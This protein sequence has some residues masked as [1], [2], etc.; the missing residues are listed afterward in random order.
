MPYEHLIFDAFIYFF[1]FAIGLGIL[2]LSGRVSRSKRFL[3]VPLVFILS[4][5]WLA[6]F[7]GSFIEPKMIR[8]SF[9]NVDLNRSSSA[10]KIEKIK[11]VVLSDLHLGPYNGQDLVKK[12][13]KRV[14]AL[15]PDLVILAGD[16]I[17]YKNKSLDQ[18][19]PLADLVAPM[20]IL[21]VTGNHD[22]QENVEEVIDALSKYHVNFLR[23]R[24]VTIEVD[25]HELFIAGVNDYW[26]DAMDLSKA[27]ASATPDQ[28]VLLVAHN[29]DVVRYL[30][31]GAKVDLMISGHTH[32]GQIRLPWLGP[33]VEP[34]TDLPREYAH[35]LKIYDNVKMLISAGLGEVGPRARLF[36]PPEVV[37][38]E[39]IF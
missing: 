14:N 20:G 10:E 31:Q 1:L 27:L 16:Y 33:L 30:P 25:Q 32:G 35:G 23:N 36:D 11:I 12:V 22:Y 4:I 29:P 3:T 8:T 34:P 13:V 17:A 26:H 7:Y 28:T 2:D 6:V 37:V 18:Y 5:I 39:T 19:A 38:L 9:Y 21:A 15:R 24:G